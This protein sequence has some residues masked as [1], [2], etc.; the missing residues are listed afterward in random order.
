HDLRRAQRRRRGGT[1][2]LRVAGGPGVLHGRV[3]D[4]RGL[5]PAGR[6]GRRPRPAA[7]DP[8]GR[9]P[10]TVGP[11]GLVHDLRAAQMSPVPGLVPRLL[12]F[13]AGGSPGGGLERR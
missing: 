6:P 5:R 8:H 9:Q 13:R 2:R 4:D 7:P 3:P 10:L 1:V 12:S 11:W